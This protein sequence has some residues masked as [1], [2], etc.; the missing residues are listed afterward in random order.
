VPVRRGEQDVRA[1]LRPESTTATTWSKDRRPG[2]LLGVDLQVSDVAV[3]PAAGLA[4]VDDEASIW[5]PLPAC[6]WPIA[7]FLPEAAAELDERWANGDLNGTGALEV[8]LK[9]C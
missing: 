9:S 8:A 2:R 7:P 5:R 4:D 3:A 6:L 1:G